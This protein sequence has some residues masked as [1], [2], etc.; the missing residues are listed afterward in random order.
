MRLGSPRIDHRLVHVNRQR[1]DALGESLHCFRQ[2]SILPKHLHEEG[3][4]LRRNRRPFLARAMQ[5]LT[6]FRIG[7]GMSRIAVG[8]AGLRQQYEWSRIRC[9]Q[10][11]GE[12][13][14]DERINM[15]VVS[16][17]TLTRIHA[18]TMTVWVMRKLGVPKK[19]ANASAFKANQSSPKT[20]CR[21]R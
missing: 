6:V 8:L 20:D 10:A 14:E 12:I 13:E 11:E 1:F 21:C 15:N 4:L 9:L 2:L 7:E 17:R 16:P 19:R 5:S 18:A 3:R